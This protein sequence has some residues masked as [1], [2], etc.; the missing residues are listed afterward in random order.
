MNKMLTPAAEKT[1]RQISNNMLIYIPMLATLVY[2]ANRYYFDATG[3]AL[4]LV[5][6][7]S[8]S[9]FLTYTIFV[10]K[11]EKTTSKTFYTTLASIATVSLGSYT[12]LMLIVFTINRFTMQY[13]VMAVLINAVFAMIGSCFFVTYSYG[14]N[15]LKKEYR[16]LITTFSTIIIMVVLSFTSLTFDVLLT[17]AL[18]LGFLFSLLVFSYGHIKTSKFDLQF[19]K[20]TVKNVFTVNS[21]KEWKP[22]QIMCAALFTTPYIV[23][24]INGYLTAYIYLTAILMLSIIGFT[25]NALKTNLILN[26]KD[27]YTGTKKSRKGLLAFILTGIIVTG[28]NILFANQTLK[29]FTINNINAD[30]T[31]LFITLLICSLPFMVSMLYIDIYNHE[32]V[33]KKVSIEV[34]FLTSLTFGLVIITRV[35]SIALGT[36]SFLTYVIFLATCALADMKKGARLV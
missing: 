34:A 15:T 6:V 24:L 29:M 1:L 11:D 27:N 13:D 4:A 10:N 9:I 33:F 3:K 12:I 36:A 23:L 32:F 26:S 14:T 20:E 25:H 2:F 18:T 35:P 17:S 19:Y 28:L 8:L 16:N 5:I 21:F 31:S 30:Y 22:N 7:S